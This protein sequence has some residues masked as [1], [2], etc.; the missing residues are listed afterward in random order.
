MI[1]HPEARVAFQLTSLKRNT[2]Y[3]KIKEKKKKNNDNDDEDT[4]DGEGV[5]N[6]RKILRTEK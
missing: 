5:Q 6:N 1:I 2:K 4:D 3:E